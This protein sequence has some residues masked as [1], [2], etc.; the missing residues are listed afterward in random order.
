MTNLREW[1]SLEKWEVLSFEQY[2]KIVRT[3]GGYVRRVV[4]QGVGTERMR[5]A[6]KKDKWVN[7]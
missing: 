2:S 1:D 7:T 4:P 3:K 6:L 5:E